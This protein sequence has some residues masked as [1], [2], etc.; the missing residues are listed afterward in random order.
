MNA[1]R[2]IA[3]GGN[4]MIR[5]IDR[6]NRHQFMRSLEQQFRLR[7]EIF[8]KE[9]G[10]KEFDRDGIYEKDQY[11]DDHASYLI[12]IDEKQNVIGSSRIYPTARPHMLSEQF[13]ALVEGAVPQR[14]DLLEFTRLAICKRMRGSGVYNELFLGLQEFCLERGF[15]GATTLVRSF[16]IPVVEA[17]GMEVAPLG[18]SCEIDGEMCT[19]IFIKASAESV[20][21][22]RKIAG[23]SGTVMESNLAPVRRIA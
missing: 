18:R 21:R 16:R 11:D 20:M 23:I 14:A 13:A 22:M 15:S 10:W 12:S 19:A 9:R 1:L 17:A 3:C 8:V 6:T 5:V 7:H 4:D 2:I